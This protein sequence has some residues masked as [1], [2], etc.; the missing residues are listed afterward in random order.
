MQEE[1]FE[2]V[3][4]YLLRRQ[5]K[6]AEYISMRRIRG[7]C[8]EQSGGQGRGSQKVAVAGGTGPGGSVG[9][10]GGSRRG[11]GGEEV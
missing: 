7:L 6:A 2:E 10:G 5:N 1:R 9:G 3:E 4:A 8:K 11:G